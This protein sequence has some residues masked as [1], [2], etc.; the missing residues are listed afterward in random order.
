MRRLPPLT[1]LRAF[2]AAARHLSFKAAADEL[3]LTPTAISHQIRLLETVAGGA[4]FRRRPRPLTLTS[5]GAALFLVVRGNFETI[6]EAFA[7]VRNEV[8]RRQ[9]ESADVGSHDGSGRMRPL[10]VAAP[11]PNSDARHL[12]TTPPRLSLVVMPFA[13]IGGGSEQEYFADG[14]T[15]SLTTDLSRISVAFVIGHNTA[16]VY[17]GSAIDLR[18]VGRDLNVRYALLGSVQRGGNQLRVNVQLIDCNLATHLWAE[19]FDQALADLFEIQDEIV[20][21][22]ASQ[23]G[24]QLVEAEA[25][26]AE[27]SPD[28]DSMALYFRA[29]ALI[30]RGSIAGYLKPADALLQRALQLDPN[31][32]DA[33]AAKDGWIWI[34]AQVSWLT[35]APR[36]SPQ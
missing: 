7:G 22:L 30:N 34:L 21:R 9:S 16:F 31:N 12:V 26:R 33:L 28:P 13:N 10:A 17:K 14:I 18:Q 27:R 29:K 8:A 15:E 2:E 6:A 5:A 3:G 11:R 23:L 19:R 35:T 24:A 36:A 32:V 25:R 4:L 20:A 1:A